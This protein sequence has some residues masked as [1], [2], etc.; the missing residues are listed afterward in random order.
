MQGVRQAQVTMRCVKTDTGEITYQL[1]RKRV[2]NINLRVYP[3]GR[4]Q[5]SASPRVQAAYIDAFVQGKAVFIQRAMLRLAAAG[6][7][8]VSPQKKGCGEKGAAQ[9]GSEGIVSGES[10]WA[11]DRGSTLPTTAEEAVEIG[12]RISQCRALC[13]AYAQEQYAEMQARGQGDFP[14]PVLYFREMTSRWGSCIPA[15]GRITLNDYL[16]N[17]PASCIRYVVVHEFCHMKVP[18]HSERFWALVA[19]YMPDWKEQRQRLKQ[20]RTAWS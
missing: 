20:V 12:K 3:D 9:D 10:G 7:V 16:A 11:E 4:V 14:M 2:K 13:M 17:A 19:S 5:V 6:D 18:N 8:P 1:T 15:K